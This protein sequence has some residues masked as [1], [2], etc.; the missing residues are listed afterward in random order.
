[1]LSIVAPPVT[2]KTKR[3][4][5]FWESAVTVG[6]LC[7]R[8]EWS[9]AEYDDSSVGIS[10][11]EQEWLCRPNPAPTARTGTHL[12][13]RHLGHGTRNNAECPTIREYKIKKLEVSG[14]KRE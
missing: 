1:M 11:V 4:N 14:I 10:G 2:F 7:H 3:L 5:Q 9:A 13:L 6:C 8:V 12:P